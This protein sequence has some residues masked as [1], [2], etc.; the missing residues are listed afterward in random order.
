ME[1]YDIN[2]F[3]NVLY[4]KN[5]LLTKKNKELSNF[6]KE[7]DDYLVFINTFIVLTNID[8]GFLL[9]DKTIPE[10]ILDVIQVNR[11]SDELNDEIK[12]VLNDLILYLNGLNNMSDN[13]KELYINQYVLYNAEVRNVN[14][15]DSQQ[16][17]ETLAFDAIAVIAL[18]TN[19]E[20]L[21]ADKKRFLISLNYLMATVPEFFE[22]DKIRNFVD[23]ILGDLNID[24]DRNKRRFKKYLKT[25]R[26]C[27]SKITVKEE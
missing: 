14:F 2:D 3:F 12:N 10:K 19:N 17:F 7:L 5:M 11:Y 1:K 4:L 16:L 23:D 13:M 18:N 8:S 22:D 21:I 9:L 25:T 20:E 24:N 15:L 27:F 6:Y 26:E